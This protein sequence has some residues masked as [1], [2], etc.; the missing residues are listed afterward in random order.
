MPCKYC[1]SS[2]KV[3]GKQA[4]RMGWMSEKLA[5]FDLRIDFPNAAMAI[6]KHKIEPSR[7]C[8]DINDP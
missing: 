8:K 3:E 1:R 4:F 2:P 7:T 6:C 5:V